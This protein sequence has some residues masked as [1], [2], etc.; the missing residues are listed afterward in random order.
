MREGGD[1]V[2]FADVEACG[3]DIAHG[4]LDEVLE[5]RGVGGELVD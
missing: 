2:E 3:E 5:P 4:P 1:G